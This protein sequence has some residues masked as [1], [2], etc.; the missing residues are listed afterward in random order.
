ML[1]PS[2]V[3]R[4]VLGYLQQE[5]LVATCRAFILE[6]PDLKEYAEHSTDMGYIPA[7]ILSLFGK[8]LTTILNEYV[9]MKAKETTTEVPA[10]MTSL[11]KKLDYTLS[12]IRSLQNSAAFSNNQRA[13]TRNGIMD[14]RRQRIVSSQQAA[15]SYP[16]LLSV[17]HLSG[18]LTT[19][20]L[21]IREVIVQHTPTVSHSINETQCV[22]QLE[23]HD[24]LHLMHSEPPERRQHA[25]LLSPGRRKCDL[26]RRRNAASLS[27]PN[28]TVRNLLPSI[29]S[30]TEEV[31]NPPPE[32]GHENFPQKV[33]ENAREKIL[34]DK[35]LQ[36]K[37]AENINKF[38]A[39]DGNSNVPQLPRQMGGAAS[40]QEQTLDEF[41][42]LQ[43]E[44]HMSEEAIQD[45]L[46]QTESDPAFQA[47][48]DLF[49]CGKNTTQG[50]LEIT[51][52]AIMLDD[53][54][55][56]FTSSPDTV[57]QG[58]SH[59]DFT[60]Q[61][62]KNVFCK[63]K[64]KT[65]GKSKKTK[66]LDQSKA[67]LKSKK[68]EEKVQDTT[69][70]DIINEKEGPF[71]AEKTLTITQFQ[72]ELYQKQN[73][74]NQCMEAGHCSQ[75]DGETPK[76]IAENEV[77]MEVEDEALGAN[78]SS[79]LKSKEKLVPDYENRQRL[80]MESSE[81]LTDGLSETI[82]EIND[83]ALLKE[84]T[85]PAMTILRDQDD[86]YV[87][88][89]EKV[90]REVA[91]NAYIENQILD[92]NLTVE[93]NIE[94]SFQSTSAE[95]STPEC[96][97]ESE[98]QDKFSKAGS[99]SLLMAGESN[100]ET[101][102]K[103][104]QPE[105]SGNAEEF[106]ADAHS[107]F[108]DAPQVKNLNESPRMMDS[109]NSRSVSSSFTESC[110]GTE[111]PATSSQPLSN[112]K[113][114]DPV[115]SAESDVTVNGTG[116]VVSYS[117][118]KSESSGANLNTL[119]ETEGS[120]TL[121]TGQ[122]CGV[123]PSSVVSLKIIISDS[124]TYSGNPELNSGL[125][126]ISGESVPTIILSSPGKT[127]E[128]N[129]LP[130]NTSSEAVGS[131][132]T[133]QNVKEASVDQKH[134]A[135]QPKASAA[136]SI[137]IYPDECTVFSAAETAILPKES[138]FIHLIPT[139]V[140]N[141]DQSDGIFITVT[142]PSTMGNPATTQSNVM[143]FPNSSAAIAQGQ[144]PQQL[145]VTPTKSNTGF[146][147]NPSVSPNYSQGSTFI[148]AS[149]VQPMLPEMVGMIPVSVMGSTSAAVFSVTS[150]Q[151]LSMPTASVHN[152]ATTIH[153]LPIPLKPK[154]MLKTKILSKPETSSMT[155]SAGSVTISSTLPWS[156][157][158]RSGISESSSVQ[159]KG[160]GQNVS[161]EK[162]TA[163]R[164]SRPLLSH[165]RVLCFDRPTPTV[166]DK[167]ISPRGTSSQQA[168]SEPKSWSTASKGDDSATESTK[169]CLVTT[170][171]SDRGE[172][173]NLS[174]SCVSRP[175]VVQDEQTRGKETEN[176]ISIVSSSPES[177][178]AMAN[179][180][181]ELVSDSEK[182]KKQET[183]KLP[184][185]ELQNKGV[186]NESSA[187]ESKMEGT[188]S[189]F[190]GV[191]E[192]T[193][194]RNP[195][196]TVTR[197]PSL[198]TPLAKQATEMLHD[199]QWQSPASK[200]TDT[201]DVPVPRTPGSGVR[202]KQTDD[203]LDGPR[204]SVCKRSS[205][206]VGG[207]GGGAAPRPVAPPATPDLPACS[208]ASETGSENS[209]N[210]AAHTLMILSRATIA[211]NN[212]MT[213]L[214]ESTQQLRSSRS[215]S[216]KRKLEDSVETERSTRSSKKDLQTSPSSSKKSKKHKRRKLDS[217]PAG[218]DVDKFLSSLHYD[219]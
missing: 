11:W 67:D 117:S 9:T 177:S 146:T 4:L 54:V 174:E 60:E 176:R 56:T 163:G 147:I 137:N 189:S 71:E 211:R 135:L 47:L 25:G 18:Q 191:Q 66:T 145:M 154:S 13:R 32:H 161:G 109:G 185:N 136:S 2:D 202:D 35:S 144:T 219:E 206:E 52:K 89:E 182:Q 160:S 196:R 100:R 36:E 114:K 170:K 26:P 23:T 45:I 159:Q 75:G 218:M 151:I 102:T 183:T 103:E 53:N 178:E 84:I 83:Q 37:L 142:D 129:A 140:A 28:V 24:D 65:D 33:I 121:N 16:G 186:Q 149:P 204:T 79:A 115:S 212:G 201:C 166:S 118:L 98:G 57:E 168:L 64:S 107:F 61:H 12:Q 77:E 22:N 43:G 217:F 150:S 30:V 123:D 96:H 95:Q 69:L 193:P 128:K 199:I 104:I 181:N 175:K 58:E 20:P 171:N 169:S 97:L 29:A 119:Q 139:P 101:P 152:T 19:S 42:G 48:F 180:E 6:S 91:D 81:R 72:T 92:A 14:K 70:H 133:S 214:K 120:K 190:V 108:P 31:P 156:Q 74:D 188:H 216:K 195:C 8:N 1:L 192:L 148:I 132:T 17:S 125:T 122:L 87:N 110:V 5:K 194:K 68:Q 73:S 208:P 215:A 134:I 165:R 3:A 138:G 205:E 50:E 49:D 15:S 78:E 59:E 164:N 90:H 157:K 155:S 141:F 126:S 38:L 173:S 39:S 7:C 131:V 41:L 172:K 179:K 93:D 46:E 21:P 124:P 158:Q 197:G 27:L 62:L 88:P 167:I 106:P 116:V 55:E 200:Q 51:E 80:L 94:V 210:M 44:I 112:D 143:V 40:I 111:V 85:S 198:T 86:S 162:K 34:S 187:P 130:N 127:P 153:K 184:V 105:D 207:G 76:V 209:V 63:K 99:E 82:E 213:P 10:M 113:E 203:T